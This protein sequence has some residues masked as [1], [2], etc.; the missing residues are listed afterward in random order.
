MKTLLLV[1]TAVTALATAA[2]GDA[3]SNL[4]DV[5]TLKLPML[6]KDDLKQVLFSASFDG[7]Y[8]GTPLR[9]QLHNP[10]RDKSI[11]GIVIG[12]QSKDAAGQEQNIEVFVDMDCGP[13][14]SADNNC[15][16]FKSE[17]IAKRSPV[18]VLKEVHYVVPE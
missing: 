9:Y 2:I 3:A 8:A 1:L 18:I 11:A 10:F 6:S 5:K 14:Q 17:E 13:L 15:H 4:R 7:N 12:V 16:F